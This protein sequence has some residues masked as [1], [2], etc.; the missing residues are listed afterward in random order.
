MRR[1][2][3][4]HGLGRVVAIA[5]TASLFLLNYPLRTLFESANTEGIVAMLT[6]IGVACVLRDRCW[7]GAARGIAAI[8]EGESRKVG[9]PQQ[10]APPQAAAEH[11]RI[12]RR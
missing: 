10:G 8:E 11:G 5:F 6:A 9:F 7:L 12:W 1:T 3:R 2:L 4:E